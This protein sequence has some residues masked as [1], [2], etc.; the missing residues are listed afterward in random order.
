MS[1]RMI[2]DMDFTI[3]YMVPRTDWGQVRVVF[4]V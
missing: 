2:A 4:K 3:F 1:I